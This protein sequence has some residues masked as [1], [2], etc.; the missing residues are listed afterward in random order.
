[1]EN[2]NVPVSIYDL[3][4]INI[5]EKS[6]ILVTASGSRYKDDVWSYSREIEQRNLKDCSKSINWKINLLNGSYLTDKPYESLLITLKD[7]IY[8]YQIGE[9]KRGVAPKATTILK[10][11][12]TLIP[13]LRWMVSE[14]L[15]EFRLLNAENVERY[16]TYLR[17]ANSRYGKP[18]SDGEMFKR[19]DVINDLW[20]CG[21]FI[22]NGLLTNPFPHK[23]PY[24]LSGISKEKQK[25]NRFDFIPDHIALALG[26]IAVNYVENLSKNI[27]DAYEATKTTFDETL[28]QNS[29]AEAQR[30]SRKAANKYG[31]KYVKEVNLDYGNLRT[32]C[33]IVVA[34]F[35]GIRDSE[36]ASLDIGCI[37]NDSVDG[38]IWIR[39]HHYKT[40]D[41]KT[42][43]LW[44]VPP[45]VA[46]AVNVAERLTFRLRSEVINNINGLNEDLKAPLTSGKKLEDIKNEL[47]RF[48]KIK[49]AL[50]LVKSSK[51]EGKISTNKTIHQQLLEFIKTHDV[52]TFND[53]HWALHPHQF[54][55]TFVRFMVKNSMNLKYLQ[56]H[57]KHVS[58]DMTAWY[59]IEDTALT[60]EIISYYS[61]LTK[62]VLTEIV[63]SKNI[64]GKGGEIIEQSRDDYFKGV[65]FKTRDKVIKA[66]ADTVTL[67]STGVS[68]C[69]G[70]IE[71]GE[72]SG[73]H[74]CMIDP[75]NV[76]KCS[77]AII[78][79]EHLPVWEDIRIRNQELL[80]IDDLGIDQKKTI[81]NF[82]STVVSP[83]IKNLTK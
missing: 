76:N 61:E 1:M 71:N 29:E 70:D 58:L 8:T 2:N 10:T 23:K 9:S 22:S 37:K 50:W 64:A 25:E 72:C 14:F 73:V 65:V 19:L 53:K 74:G 57:F 28:L 59:D 18:I 33:Y 69:L 56:E 43:A 67:R 82:L 46:K 47:L 6:L 54:R 34:M 51:L 35:S 60:G 48:A 27:L 62:D 45:V 32:A 49:D 7:F 44:M 36:V 75:S 39:G 21:E 5:F 17:V 52:P 38:Y 42:E 79:E 11:Y 24:E 30:R 55:R 31:Y 80:E 20:L 81:S 12:R 78:T 77:Q 4:K 68:W 40:V 83:V 26:T 63:D 15:L 41:Q 66:M 16:I 3:N 13:L